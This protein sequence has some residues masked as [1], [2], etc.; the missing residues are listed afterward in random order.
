M[1]LVP[2]AAARSVTSCTAVLGWLRRLRST[3]ARSPPGSGAAPW[4]TPSRTASVTYSGKPPVVACDNCTSASGRG[5][6]EIASASRAVSADSSGLRDSS[7]S[8]SGGPHPRDPARQFV[9]LVGAVVTQRPDHQD[10]GGGVQTEAEGDEGQRLLVAPLEVFQDQQQRAVRAEQRPGE[11]FEEAMVLPGIGHDPGPVRGLARAPGPGSAGR[12]RCARPGPVPRPPPGPPGSAASPPPGPWPAAPTSRSTGCWPP[13]RPAPAPSRRP[14]RS[15]WSSP[16]RR[17]RG[18]AP[19]PGGRRQLPATG[20]SADSVP[21][22]GR[23]AAPRPGRGGPA[24]Q[25]RPWPPADAGSL[26]ASKPAT[27]WRVAGSGVTPSSRSST[28]AQWW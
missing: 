2:T 15:A 20:P 24:A 22:T 19:A 21:G 11:T 4:S 23:R 13:R 16:P 12:L 7:V 28:E 3:A 1:K 17:R 25:F 27:A 5:R 14:P 6:P 18:P 8:S 26:R 9:I 10:L